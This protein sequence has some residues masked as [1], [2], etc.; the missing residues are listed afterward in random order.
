MSNKNLLLSA[1][2]A[3]ATFA[4]SPAFA[5]SE[6]EIIV[7][8]TKRET[9]LQDT[10]ISVSVT[11]AE[12]IE[13]AQILDIL[14]LQSVVPNFRV[15]QLQNSANASLIIRGFGNGG[16]NLGIEPAVGVFTGRVLGHRL[17]TCQPLSVLR[18]WQGHKPHSLVKMPQSVF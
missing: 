4:T 3:V 9:T 2:L 7:T 5:Q 6:D 17:V 12:V 1:A 8:A 15:S 18:F 16:N 10:P 14:S 13:Q 11:S